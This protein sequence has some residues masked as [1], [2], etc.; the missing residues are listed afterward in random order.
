MQHSQN[1][2]SVFLKPHPLQ[3]LP[4]KRPAVNTPESPSPSWD[5]NM[6]RWLTVSP[7]LRPQGASGALNTAVFYCILTSSTALETQISKNQILKWIR[8][9]FVHLRTLVPIM[10]QRK[11]TICLEK[12][13]FKSW[14]GLS[15]TLKYFVF[16]FILDVVQQCWMETICRLNS[17]CSDVSDELQ[18][19]DVTVWCWWDTEI[20][21]SFQ[22]YGKPFGLFFLFVLNKTDTQ[23]L[24][25]PVWLIVN[26]KEPHVE[27]ST[28][29]N[30][31]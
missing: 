17:G 3:V 6:C 8:F 7:D 28:S 30:N 29:Q 24:R 22:L 2:G 19:I 25:T 1:S 15:A 23:T 11:S 9:A 5:R 4:D 10:Q 27:V 12:S 26:N 13:A 20:V 14:K 31:N 21:Q 18:Q 16:D